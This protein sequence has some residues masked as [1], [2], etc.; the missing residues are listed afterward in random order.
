MRD[1]CLN[2]VIKHL[3]QAFIT[4]IESE[5]GYPNHI[6]L[7]IGHLAEASEECFG[8]SKELA[9]EIRQYRLILIENT[10]KDQPT[11]IPYFDLLNKTKQLIKE[12]GCGTCNKSSES[13]KDRLIKKI[14]Q[15]KKE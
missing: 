11:Q 4:H 3:S 7:T 5:S 14:E 12:K 9:E 1:F 10:V 6:Y 13:F 8:V 15:I 2:C